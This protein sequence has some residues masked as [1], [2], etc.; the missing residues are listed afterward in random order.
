MNNFV[1]RKGLVIGII[2]LLVGANVVTGF[3]INLKNT[4]ISKIN[5][6]GTTLYV[7][8]S[9]PGNYSKIQEAIGNASI[10]DTII[11]F[12]GIYYENVIVN[13]SLI[14]KSYSQNPYDTIIHAIDANNHVFDVKSD[15][16]IIM[17]F[18]IEGTNE[19]AGL[20]GGIRLDNVTFC[21]ISNNI[22][23]NNDE[24]IVLHLNSKSNNIY[25]NFITFNY[26][27]GIFLD[28]S[29]NNTFINNI[30]TINGGNG[31]CFYNSSYYNYVNRNN[32]SNNG[33]RGVFL[34]ESSNNNLFFHNTFYDN[35]ENARDSCINDWDNGYP[36]G[37][38]FW[39]DYDGID[40]DG[41]GIGDTPYNIS[42][43]NNQDRYPLMQINGNDPPTKPTI[44]GPLSGNVLEFYDYD[45]TAVDPEGDDMTYHVEWNDGG[46]DEGF[47]ESGG[48]FTLTHSW[49]EQGT[50]TIRAKLIDKYGA[51]SD[52]GELEVT[53]P[54]NRAI[55]TPFLDFIQQHPMIFQ[56]LQRFLKL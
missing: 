5:G 2:I 10:G 6:R 25:N 14:I 40:N 36:T 31:I 4:T 34:R 30:V 56:L 49:S 48:G 33:K 11:V 51:E 7:G 39:D 19:S 52:W 21:D 8:G 32:I 17:G 9:G 50:F 22:L 28:H 55:N 37:G 1:F 16:V 12:S 54:R 43:G 42:A 35:D 18:T 27:N 13:L 38:N 20:R 23:L 47:A 53:M 45:F 44:D 41:D 3:T 26:D 46:I 29:N 15:N 24:G